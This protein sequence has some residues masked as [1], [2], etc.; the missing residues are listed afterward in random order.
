MAYLFGSMVGSYLI[1]KV[2]EWLLIKR[3]I[4]NYYAKVAVSSII[5][6]ILFVMTWQRNME[7]RGSYL[8]D[9]RSAVAIVGTLLLPVVRAVWHRIRVTIADSKLARAE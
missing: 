7:T 4:K 1:C 3:I 8:F 5:V 9:S 6:T 2:L